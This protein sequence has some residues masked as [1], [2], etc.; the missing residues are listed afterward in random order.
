MHSYDVI[1]GGDAQSQSTSQE[2]GLSQNLQLK[3]TIIFT[4]KPVCEIG[5]G[6]EFSWSVS[7]R[8]GNQYPKKDNRNSCG[9]DGMCNGTLVYWLLPPL[10]FKEILRGSRN[11]ID[12]TVSRKWISSENFT[13]E[14]GI[15]YYI[16]QNILSE[17]QSITIL[18]RKDFHVIKYL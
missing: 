2:V 18:N 9:I 1:Y 7:R 13:A 5:L 6:C 17:I 3:L 8:Y 11:M 16:F 15:V 14:I 4:I 10:E 12:F